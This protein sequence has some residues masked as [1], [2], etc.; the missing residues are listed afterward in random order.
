MTRT[1]IT[2]TAALVAAALLLAACGSASPG[3]GVARIGTSSGSKPAGGTSSSPSEGGAVSQQ[4]MVAYAQCMRS[5]GVSEFPEPTEGRLVVHGSDRNG[6]VTGVNPASPTFAAAQKACGKLAPAGLGRSITPQQQ[7]QL[8]EGALKMSQCMRSH[9]VPNF[10]DPKFSG[11]AVQIK[12][13]PGSGVDPSSPVFQA[14]QK[15]CQSK[16]PGIPA[17]KGGPTEGGFPTSGGP[18]GE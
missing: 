18:K 14:A 11:D 15:A 6:K 7:K 10:P 12:I 2:S 3:P 1:K 9:G 13:S 5:H 17:E 4:K 8:Q 16:T